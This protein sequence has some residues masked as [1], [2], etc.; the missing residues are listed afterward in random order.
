MTGAAPSG[1]IQYQSQ[2]I[3]GGSTQMTAP[4]PMQRPT[5][6]NEMLKQFGV[7]K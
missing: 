7:I 2:P 1:G 5:D 3:Q 6:I 4:P